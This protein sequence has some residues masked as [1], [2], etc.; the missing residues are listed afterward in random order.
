MR[1]EL[2][3]LTTAQRMC[4]RRAVLG[5]AACMVAALK[6]TCSQPEA[7]PVGQKHHQGVT[8]ARRIKAARPP[9]MSWRDSTAQR[10]PG[11]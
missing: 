10:V 1:A 8:V 9:H 11:A 5:P 4:R 2:A 6:S 7:M 3:H